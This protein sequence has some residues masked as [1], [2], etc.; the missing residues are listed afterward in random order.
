MAMCENCPSPH[1]V[2]LLALPK[3]AFFDQLLSGKKEARPGGGNMKNVIEK[4]PN[5]IAWIKVV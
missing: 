2:I 3:P 4:S 1:D 5:H